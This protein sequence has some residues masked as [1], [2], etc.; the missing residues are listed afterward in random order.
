MRARLCKFHVHFPCFFF[1]AAV[2]YVHVPAPRRIATGADHP[3]LQGGDG[4]GVQ[5]VN[6]GGGSGSL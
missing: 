4:L 5:T 2:S 3:S 1:P 6:H